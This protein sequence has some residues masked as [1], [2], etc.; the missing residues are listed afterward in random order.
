MVN[1]LAGIQPIN[2]VFDGQARCFKIS[3]TYDTDI[4]V[5]SCSTNF[6]TI[7]SRSNK[8]TAAICSDVADALFLDSVVDPIGL[9][10]DTVV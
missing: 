1:A 2:L 5:S 9:A 4:R 8:R 3:I 7:E 10:G 6:P